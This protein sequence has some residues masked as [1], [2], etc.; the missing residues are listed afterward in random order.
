[1]EVALHNGVEG[2]E[3]LCGGNC[4]CGTCHVELSPEL[5]ARL[6]APQEAEAEMLA[7]LEDRTPTS[8]LSCQI[9]VSELLLG[10]RLRVMGS[11]S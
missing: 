1:M 5:Y 8:R 7:L 11:G 6:G 2:I 9:N 4:S 3:G 10:A